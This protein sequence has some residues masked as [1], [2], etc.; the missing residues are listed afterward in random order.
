MRRVGGAAAGRVGGRLWAAARRVGHEVSGRSAVDSQGWSVRVVPRSLE[1]TTFDPG[2]GWNEVAEDAGVV[3]GGCGGGGVR[4]VA[5]AA[6][7]AVHGLH[8]SSG[9]GTWGID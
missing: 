2:D 3:V 7:R 8:F 5:L 9:E 1:E 4:A 6:G